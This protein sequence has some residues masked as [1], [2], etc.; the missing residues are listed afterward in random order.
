MRSH[1]LRFALLLVLAVWTS[2]LATGAWAADAEYVI[3]ISIDGLRGD[4][5]ATMMRD[6]T[7]LRNFR[8]FVTEGA[9]TFNARTDY[10]NTV[11]LPNHATMLTGRPVLQPAGQPNTVH[12][13]YIWNVDPA[14]TTTL[15]N[16]GGNP[17][18]T[19]FASV[20]DV[21]HDAGL[22]TALY[23][24]KSKFVLY[25]RSWDGAHGAPDEVPPDN[26]SDKIDGY[27]NLWSATTPPTAAPMHAALIANMSASPVRY[28]F[29]HYQDLDAIGHLNGWG[30]SA[31]Q[32]GVRVVDGYLRDI[33]SLVETQPQLAGRTTVV[34]SADHGGNNT[35]HSDVTIYYNY[36]V[37]FFVWGAGVARGVNI[38]ALNASTRLDP[39]TGRPDYN[40]ATQPI[41][42]G[43]GANLALKLLG[44]GAIRGS[45]INARQD[46]LVRVPVAVER[47]S[48]SAMKKAWR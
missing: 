5:L 4:F 2:A 33:F 29:V 15:H 27:V 14:P 22:S 12:H 34:L 42:N 16:S 23:A 13:G 28:C 39:G 1:H 47:S 41:R 46:L 36:N 20:F 44:L 11:T 18:V 21:V 32:N 6:T 3:H 48:W 19:Y 31:W 25:D 38:Y 43:D 17:N 8:R 35:N 24:S 26:G 37:P 9:S 45:S 7:Q 40:A 30:S 10:A